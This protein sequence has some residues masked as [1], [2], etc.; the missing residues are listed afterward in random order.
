MIYFT[1]DLHFNHKNILAYEP[2]TRPFA[3]VEEMNETLISNWNNVVTPE[4]TVYVLGDFAMG[5]AS[6]V[7]DLV[8][9]LN[10]TIKLIRGN[11]DT[12]AKLKIYKELG[13]EIKDIDYI[14]YKGRF[15]ILCHFPIA[16]EE[17]MQMV[18]NDNSEVINV[19]G[20]V[21]SNAKKGFY[22]GTYHIGVDTN[23]LTPISIEQVWSE[24]W[25]EEMMTP[26]VQEYK[27]AYELNPNMEQPNGRGQRAAAGI[28]LEDY[29]G[30]NFE[31]TVDIALIHSSIPLNN[32]EKEIGKAMEQLLHA[33][34]IKGTGKI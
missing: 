20:H 12:P 3:S 27:T 19:Y 11:H 13:I 32:T 4:D 14:S 1:S 10:G 29:C 34:S 8:S 5:Q 22:K 24:S 21:H 16:S 6:E 15:F 2:V 25:P 30:P 7:K 33:A 18:V 23:D 28:F 31:N 17:F 9:R 26:E